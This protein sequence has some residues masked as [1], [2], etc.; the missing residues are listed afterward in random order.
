MTSER[1]Q[2]WL[3]NFVKYL[4]TDNADLIPLYQGRINVTGEDKPALNELDER[5]ATKDQIK[6]MWDVFSAYCDSHPL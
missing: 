6:R 1:F 2:N 4:P 3:D 5:Y